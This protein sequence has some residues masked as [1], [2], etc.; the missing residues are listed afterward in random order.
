M[1]LQSKKDLKAKRYY[2][3]DFCCL[4]SCSL[5]KKRLFYKSSARSKQ[6]WDIFKEKCCNIKLYQAFF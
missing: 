1:G 6:E 4:E 2:V 3:G 5:A